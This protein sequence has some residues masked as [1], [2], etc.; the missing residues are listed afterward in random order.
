M[1]LEF[2][3]CF[4]TKQCVH[5]V[6]AKVHIFNS[7]VTFQ[8]SQIPPRVCILVLFTYLL[9]LFSVFLFSCPVVV[10]YVRDYS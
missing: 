4:D 8:L 9:L 10:L 2:R 7:N 5:L 1:N 6:H 3:C